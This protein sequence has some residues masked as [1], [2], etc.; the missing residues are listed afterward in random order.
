M[1]PLGICLLLASPLAR[2]QTSTGEIRITVVDPSGAVVPNAEVTLTGAET[3]NVLRRL[4]SNEAGI[5]SAPLL[6][7]QTYDI[8]VAAPGF[9]QLSRNGIVLHVGEVLALRLE[10]QPGAVTQSVTVVGETPMLEESSG[11]LAQVFEPRQI[12]QLPLNGRNYLELGRLTLGAV[13]SH[14]SR[15]QTFSAYGNSGIQN[16]FLLDGARNQNY[17]R[18]LDNRARD[19]LRPPLDALAEFS[20]E[21]ANFSAQYGASAGAVVT[22]V[23]KSGTNQLHGSAYWFLRNSA[24]DARDFFAPPGPKPLL[25]QNQMGGSAGGPIRQDRAWIFAAYEGTGIRRDQTFTATVPTPAMKQGNFGSTRIFNPFSTRPNPSGSGF[26]RE[27]FPN[28]TIPSTMIDKIGQAVVQRYP[29]PNLP[30]LALNFARNAPQRQFLHNPVTRSDLQLNE[31]N[32]IFT[33][34]SYGHLNLTATPG[35]QAPAQTPAKRAIDTWGLGFGH[36]RIFSPTVVN[37]FRFNWTRLTLDQDA[38]L[39]LD[40][41]IPGMLDPVIRSSIPLFNVTGFPQIGGQPSAVG[42]GPL[43]KSSGV[44]AISDNLSKSLGRHVLKSGVEFQLIR[45]RTFAALGGRGSF[46]FNGVFTQDPQERLGTGSAVADL[47]LGVANTVNTGTVALSEERGGYLGGYFEDDWSATP[48]LTLNLGLRYELFYPYIETQNRMGNFILDQD[49]PL[50]GQLI[51]SG[52]SRKPRALM[53]LDT[54]NFAPRLGLA[55]RAP[56]ASG[57]VVRGSYGI[58]YAQDQGLGVTSRMT[59]NPPFFGFG[60]A[61]VISDQLLP[62][63]GFA[64]SS[65]ALAPRPAPINPKDFVLNPQATSPLRSW[66]QRYTSPYVQQWNFTVEKQLPGQMV[67]ETSYVGNIGL[68]MW[69]QSEANQPLVN[70]P[71]SPTT[72]RP[73]A[74][75][76]R[77]SVMRF[78]P[79]NRS[80]YE[81]LSSRVQKRLS[82]GVSFLTSFTWGHALDL[83]NPALDVCDGC[84]QTV[85]NSYDLNARRGASDQDVRL[86][87]TFGGVWDLPFGADHRWAS[88]GWAAALAGAWQVSA[89]YQAQSGYPFSI[90]LPFDNPNAG[91]TAYP[92]RVCNGQLTPWTLERYYDTNCFPSPPQFVFGNAGRNILYGPGRNSLDFAVHRRFHLPVREASVL[93]FRLE[94]FNLFNKPQFGQPGNTVGVPG[95]AR[96]GSTA[97]ANRELQAALRLAF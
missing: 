64:L 10:L 88:R 38:T 83:Q 50:F 92:D 29:D 68:H 46:G 4:K 35:L 77:A 9:S 24:L 28:N 97:V 89:I 39:P 20:V 58:F 96:I 25:V 87:Y 81:G 69:G 95:T 26:I 57:L 31:N 79:W 32:K 6:P 80:T 12:L 91:T 17:L 53:D 40:E 61:S 18:G 7:P 84:D 48:R 33:R 3:G 93:E 27:Q 45:P 22:A 14:G 90:H 2:A 54:N 1:V 65:G 66:P 15:D 55:Y 51:L 73:L 78:A 21:A 62:S 41:I 72:R 76:T 23:T 19:M 42:N 44:W 59:N 52:D 13:P 85:Q 11:T 71:G 36:T 16:A 5:A 82:H 49:D 67:W 74:Q 75:F 70:G 60:G 63:S 94:A 56:G 8:V 43:T 47:L 86:R 30:R 34:F 37:E